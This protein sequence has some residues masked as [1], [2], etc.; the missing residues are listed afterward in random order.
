LMVV[1][2]LLPLSCKYIHSPPSE[3]DIAAMQRD[4]QEIA[5]HHKAA[6]DAGSRWVRILAA[7]LD[8]WYSQCEEGLD[9]GHPVTHDCALAVARNRGQQLKELLTQAN[10]TK[11]ETEAKLHKARTACR[12]LN[13]W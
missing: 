10:E 6:A 5:I 2:F 9:A 1:V 3:E 13:V 7:K 12:G 4:D 8:P 11:S